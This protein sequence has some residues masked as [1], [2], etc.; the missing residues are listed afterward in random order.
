MSHAKV[1]AQKRKPSV[2]PTRKR[3]D[4]AL[5]QDVISVVHPH[6]RRAAEH[7]EQ[8]LGPVVEVVDELR[9]HRLELPHGR[10]EAVRLRADQSASADAAPVRNVV[11]DVRRVAHTA[12]VVRG[13]K[14]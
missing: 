3:D 10:T 2:G 6:G 7:D 5:G 9:A 4:V 1:I 14:R 11:P 13:A 8:L 12:I